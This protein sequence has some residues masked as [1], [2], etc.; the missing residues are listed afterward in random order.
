MTIRASIDVSTRVS[1]GLS[2]LLQSLADDPD[3]E[4]PPTLGEVRAALLDESPPSTRETE[5]L[6]PLDHETL[7][8]ELDALIDEFGDDAL[9]VDF[10]S[11]NASEGLSRVI[12]AAISDMRPPRVPSLAA[13]REAMV[14]GLTARLVGGGALDEDDDGNLLAEIDQL[15][16]RYGEDSLAEDFIRFE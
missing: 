7:L 2:D 5:F 11:T 13:V 6:H 9:A 3:L 8:A 15:I 1:A 12:E 4:E 10:V 14:D 16:E